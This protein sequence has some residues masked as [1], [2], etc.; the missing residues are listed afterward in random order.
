[1]GSKPVS[2]KRQVEISNQLGEIESTFYKHPRSPH[3]DIFRVSNDEQEGCTFVGRTGWH[4][5]GTFLPMP[6]KYQTM[7]F[8]SVCEG[9]ETW[10]VPLSDFYGLQDDAKSS[11]EQA[12]DDK[13]RRRSSYGLQTRAA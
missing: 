11:L 2:G 12:L 5:D 9:G 3:P 6:F 13:Q 1:M 8:H 7:H 10:F 4:I